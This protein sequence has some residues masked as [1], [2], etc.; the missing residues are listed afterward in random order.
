MTR[1]LR[2]LDCLDELLDRADAWDD[3]WQRSEVRSP[4]ARAICIANWVRHFAPRAAFRVLAVE[5]DGRLVGSLP[6]VARRRKK[7]L[8]VGSLPVND[9]GHCGDLLIDPN[10]DVDAVADQLVAGLG[11]LPWKLLWIGEAAYESPR[12]IALRQAAERADWS[13]AVKEVCRTPVVEIGDDWGAY[14]ASRKGDQRRKRKRYTRMLQRAGGVQLRV[15]RNLAPEMVEES[16][17]QGFE[18]ED[19]S[20]KGAAG[21]SVLKTPG[22]F[23]FYREE[24]QQMARWG[25]LELAFLDHNG[26]PIA[27]DYGWRAKGTHFT[28]KIG[29]DDAYRKF[30]PGQQLMMH[31]IER[32]HGEEDCRRLDFW[33]PETA[34]HGHWKT[35]SYP[36]GRVALASPRGLSPLLL[37]TFERWRQWRG[38]SEAS[39]GA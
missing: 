3:L 32:L 16:L 25:M 29:Y 22:M 34:W 26:G 23:E 10:C 35:T 15:E 18:V 13:V 38:R 31:L 19:R 7:L 17:R 20:W 5:Q 14:D 33:G 28:P 36:V 8:R 1:T 2:Q 4:S 37:K 21:S 11:T 27:F 12:W 39:A 30:G 6:L 24:A 9:W